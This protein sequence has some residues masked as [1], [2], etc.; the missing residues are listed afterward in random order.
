[1]RE[2][3]SDIAHS[4][5]TVYDYSFYT[6]TLDY[7]KWLGDE[8]REAR[9]SGNYTLRVLGSCA[10]TDVNARESQCLAAQQRVCLALDRMVHPVWRVFK[11]G[12]VDTLV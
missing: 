2:D 10:G 12:P 11:Y 6:I 4:L 5:F 1:M 3:T 8:R 9:R 7:R